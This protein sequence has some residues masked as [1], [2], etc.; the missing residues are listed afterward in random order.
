MV[1]SL[2]SF[3]V[4][5]AGYDATE[6]EPGAKFD[7]PAVRIMFQVTR[8]IIRFLFSGSSFYDGTTQD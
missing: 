4:D 1:I 8:R 2:E 7:K 5:G 3:G 6:T